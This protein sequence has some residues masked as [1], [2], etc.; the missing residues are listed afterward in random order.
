MPMFGVCSQILFIPLTIYSSPPCSFSM[1]NYYF[2]ANLT[3]YFVP[4]YVAFH[5]IACY[6]V[7]FRYMPNFNQGGNVSHTPFILLFIYLIL[8]FYFPKTKNIQLDEE[9]IV[10]TFL[11]LRIR[12][13]I[14]FDLFVLSRSTFI[15]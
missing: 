13:I 5:V 7:L 10:N 4:N 14:M 3:N 8:I 9:Y 15:L 6:F 11:C 2:L 12:N 1:V